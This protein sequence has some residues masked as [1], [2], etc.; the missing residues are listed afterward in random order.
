MA[1][2]RNGRLALAYTARV[3]RVAMAFFIMLSPIEM[4]FFHYFATPY[5]ALSFA[6]HIVPRIDS[7]QND[8]FLAQMSSSIENCP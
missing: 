3:I 4:T 7:Y 1:F 8:F 5:S 2:L 6:K